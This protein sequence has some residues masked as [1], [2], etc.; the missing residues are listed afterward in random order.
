MNVNDLPEPM[1]GIC[2][3]SFCGKGDWAAY[4][5]AKTP[6][7]I[8]QTSERVASV[9]YAKERMDLR[10][11][12]FEHFLLLSLKAQTDQNYI[13]IVLSSDV[14]P[15]EYK[16][17]LQAIARGN[18]RIKTVFSDAA[19]VHEAVWPHINELNQKYAH[20]VVTFRIDDDDCLSKDAIAEMRSYLMPLVGRWPVAYSRSNGLVMTNYKDQGLRV[21]RAYL[22][23]NS[24]GTALRVHGERTIFSFG[25]SALGKRFPA[26]NNN[27]GMGFIS[28]KTDGH[29]SLRL[30]DKVLK[31]RPD[32]TV[33]EE[34]EL[35]D[36]LKEWFPFL[37]KG[38]EPIGT[39]VSELL[40]RARAMTAHTSE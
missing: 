2:R 22:P 23:F 1:V 18:G 29:D 26:L 31:T 6:N 7:E 3:F 38:E 21:Y 11:F 8:A 15:E 12:L 33:V 16:L 28:I 36:L 9:L 14:M 40:E 10:F 35:K 37:R 17:R 32:H 39:S 30:D 20:P 24:M 34:D 4:R 25:H 27:R 19:T 5:N 13:L